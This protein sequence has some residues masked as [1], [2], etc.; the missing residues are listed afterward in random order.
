[1]KQNATKVKELKRMEEGYLV[2]K[3]EAVVKVLN[4]V[5]ITILNKLITKIRD[6]EGSKTYEVIEKK[7]SRITSKE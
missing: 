7:V 6:Y 4:P 2:L 3:K 1:M 5:E